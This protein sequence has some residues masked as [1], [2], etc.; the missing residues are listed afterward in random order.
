MEDYCMLLSTMESPPT[1]LDRY[2]GS[3][4]VRIDADGCFVRLDQPHA[5]TGDTEMVVLNGE[6]VALT[7]AIRRQLPRQP[8]WDVVD[9]RRTV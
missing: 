4:A 1:F 3:C 9:N 6:L 7:E 2:D 5:L 8:A